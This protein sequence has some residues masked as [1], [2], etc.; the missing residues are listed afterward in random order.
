MLNWPEYPP[1]TVVAVCSGRDSMTVFSPTS[2][3]GAG[4]DAVGAGR[5]AAGLAAAGFGDPPPCVAT[6]IGT[7]TMHSGHCTIGVP[8]ATSSSQAWRHLLQVRFT[9]SPI[10]PQISQP[11]VRGMDLAASVVPF[12]RESNDFRQSTM[13]QSHT[14]ADSTFGSRCNQ[15]HRAQFQILTRLFLNQFLSYS[16]C[17]SYSS[18]LRNA[19][20]NLAFCIVIRRPRDATLLLIQRE[21]REIHPLSTALSKISTPSLTH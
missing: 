9:P 10:R 5:A 12:V 20:R 15:D 17:Y 8:G 7:I 21:I 14:V 2:A 4:R 6:A 18:G 1:I 3:R 11:V 16:Y 19:F 13:I